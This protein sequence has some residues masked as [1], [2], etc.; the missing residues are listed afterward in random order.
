MNSK[1]FN[2]SAHKWVI[3]HSG[4]QEKDVGALFLLTALRKGSSSVYKA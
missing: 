2:K 1:D 4:L 3:D